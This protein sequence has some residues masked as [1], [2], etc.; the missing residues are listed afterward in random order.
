[1]RVPDS[2][3]PALHNAAYKAVAV[4]THMMTSSALGTISTLMRHSM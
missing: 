1:M 2:L 3:S 4:P